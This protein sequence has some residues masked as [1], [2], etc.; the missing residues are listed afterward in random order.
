MFFKMHHGKIVRTTDDIY[1][2]EASIPTFLAIFVFPAVLLA[3]AVKDV[4]NLIPFIFSNICSALVAVWPI[5]ILAIIT[6]YFGMSRYKNYFRDAKAIRINEVDENGILIGRMSK[7]GSTPQPKPIKNRVSSF[8]FSSGKT[9]AS[10]SA[11]RVFDFI[12]HVNE[13]VI[14]V[15]WNEIDSV[16]VDLNEKNEFDNVFIETNYGAVFE[17]KKEN[18]FWWINQETFFSN[19]RAHC[20]EKL[21]K[22]PTKVDDIESVTYTKLWLENFSGQEHENRKRKEALAQGDLLNEGQYTIVSKLG[23]GGQGSA[24]LASQNFDKEKKTVS[25]QVVLKEYILPASKG[26]SLENGKAQLLH[27]EANILAKIEHDQIVNLLDCF[28]EDHRGYLVLDYIEG[29]CL[30][31]LVKSEGAQAEELVIQWSIQLCDI[32]HYLHNLLPPIIHRD[33]TP[34]NLIV[35]GLESDNKGTIKLFDFTVAH[36][37]ESSRSSTVVGKQAYISPEQF[38]GEACPASDLYSL[39]CTIY[40]LLTGED[41]EPLS[42]SNPSAVGIELSKVVAKTTAFDASD[43]YNSALHLKAELFELIK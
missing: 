7:V 35:E 3:L 28:V 30:R 43:R 38:A 26:M 23:A 31:E 18:A 12:E 41:P 33:L 13:K 10:N 24:Y 20:G 27:H 25:S 9:Y 1:G 6:F 14:L 42:V 37:F 4:P 32:L 40:Y 22:L 15:N 29:R 17:I 21:L 34:D 8:T 16:T 5:V 19:V 39:G 11:N 36:Q 2:S